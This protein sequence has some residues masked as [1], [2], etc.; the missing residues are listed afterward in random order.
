[1][2]KEQAATDFNAFPQVVAIV[3]SRTFPHKH[4][5]TSFVEKLQP[6]TVIVSGGSDG[7]DTWAEQAALSRRMRTKIFEI[8]SWEWD[9][10]GK[11]AGRYRN[12]TL[13][14][15]LKQVGGHLIAF[16]LVDENDM[17]SRGTKHV[18]EAASRHNIPITIY[19][20]PA[21]EIKQTQDTMTRV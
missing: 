10:Y 16:P 4:W 7:V 18:I 8:E 1:M 21:S 20:A 11:K 15:Y 17:M 19:S 14:A 13:V 12:E 6:D 9:L 2:K 5:V 3:G